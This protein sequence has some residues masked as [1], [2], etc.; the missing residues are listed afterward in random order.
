MIERIESLPFAADAEAA[1]LCCIIENPVR[2]VPRVWEAQIEAGFFHHPV[3]LALW[4]VIS[5][6]MRVEQPLDP[7]SLS[8]TIR[9]KRPPGI[10]ISEFS[11]LLLTEFDESSWTGYIEILRDRFARRLA[12][13]AGSTVATEHLSGESAVAA[14]RNAT[15]RA[16]AALS[17][18][19]AVMSAKTS[20]A[21]FL[22]SIA[23]RYEAGALPGMP[24]GMDQ[25]DAH[26]GGM[27]KGELWVVGAPT[28]HG[29]SVFMLQIAAHA[30]HLDK[31]VIV[32]S[33]EMGA[34]E[35][36]GRIISCQRSIPMG[37]I[38][39]PR[40]TKKVTPIKIKDAAEK[41]AE[42]DLMICDRADLSVEAISG[43]CQRLADM[44][45]LDLIVV[46]YLQ[47]VSAPKMKGQNREQEVAGISRALKQLAKRVKCPVITATQL[48]EQGKSRESRAIEHDADCV[49]F[50][51][52]EEIKTLHFW[53][54]RNGKRGMELKVKLNGELQHFDFLPQQ[55]DN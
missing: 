21:A 23:E 20:V 18:T 4:G 24:T 52:K 50:L 48:N 12:I 40:T 38:M 5:D 47:L 45:P 31:R 6:R 34:D 39:N 8:E 14:L 9:D 42:T 3:S 35:V 51:D 26:T 7:V 53:K 41:L 13:E 29:K 37:E 33:L 43:H 11:A 32:F 55:Y 15:E 22:A 16:V 46:D 44:K 54:C 36:I 30:V 27:R 49:I 1:V 19:S 2:F 10:T 28:S 25:V 17:G